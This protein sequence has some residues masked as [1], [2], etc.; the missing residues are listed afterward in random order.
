MSKTAHWDAAHGTNGQGS[1]KPHANYPLRGFLW[2]FGIVAVPTVVIVPLFIQATAA[3][4]WSELGPPI[5]LI[6]CGVGLAIAVATGLIGALIGYGK[7][8]GGP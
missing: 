4:R 1:G 6:L 2:G 7:R 5:V 3:V 8:S